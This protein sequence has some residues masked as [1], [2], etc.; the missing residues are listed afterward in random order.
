MDLSSAPRGKTFS[1]ISPPFRRTAIARSTRVRPWSS[2]CSK[3]PKAFRRVTSSAPSQL[4]TR[5]ANPSAQREGF[6]LRSPIAGLATSSPPPPHGI[7]H[8][9]PADGQRTLLAS[10]PSP[11]LE[12]QR[13][14]KRSAR[15]PS[16][17]QQISS[18]QA[19]YLH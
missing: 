13:R 6:L 8:T 9:A 18:D 19:R 3:A 2:I 16:S 4:V 15:I 1:Y 14:T 17:S 10:P 7:C 12:I 5:F 11:C